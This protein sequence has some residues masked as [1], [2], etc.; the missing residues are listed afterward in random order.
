[1]K[2]TT[3]LRQLLAE[4]GPLLVPG[5]YD[6]ASARVAQALDYSAIY[7]TGFGMEAS[8]LGMPDIGLASQ[9]E[10]VAHAGRIA[11]AVSVP[12]ISDADT[13]YG[14]LINVHRTI[15]DFERAGIAAV[16]LEDQALPK[17]C[18][19]MAGRRVVAVEEMEARLRAAVAAREDPDFIIIARTDAKAE[20]G[21]E[22]AIARL[23]AYLVAGADMA[24]I[25]EPFTIDELRRLCAGVDGPVAMVGGNPG[26][27]E[28]MLTRDD[29]AELGAK[30]V[31][32]AVTG[33]AA[34]LKAQMDVYRDLK[35]NGTLGARSAAAMLDLHELTDL[36][37][38]A[39]WNEIERKAEAG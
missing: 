19:G 5:A 34:G 22:D 2:S 35:E 24:M 25:A 37:G 9:T 29:Y 20:H 18:G 30:L 28:T 14:G 32:Y 27:P 36:M 4:E 38:L 10:V 12:V 39:D 1:M 3:R 8:M 31:L 11:A 7:L 13:G 17:R 26:W 16:H 23:N 21:V 33:L 15:R 6:G